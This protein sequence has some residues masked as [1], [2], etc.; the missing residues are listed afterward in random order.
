MQII[1]NDTKVARRGKPLT[2][3]ILY[4]NLSLVRCRQVRGSALRGNDGQATE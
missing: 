3:D 4:D 1:I 2:I